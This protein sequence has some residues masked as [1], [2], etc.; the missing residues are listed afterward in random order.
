MTLPVHPNSISIDSL[1]IEFGVSGTKSLADFYSGGG[2]VPA[3]TPGFPGGGGST[4][5]PSNGAISLGN[6]H[7]SS[8][9]FSFAITSNQLNLNLYSAAVAAGWNQ[10]S[11]VQCQIQANVRVV[12]TVERTFLGVDAS[13]EWA[14]L[15][16]EGFPN[17]VTLTNYGYILGK[18]GSGGAGNGV[19]GGHGSHAIR[20]NGNL[21]IFNYGYIAGGGGGGGGGIYN[22]NRPGRSI[23]LGGG[24]GAGGGPGGG[25]GNNVPSF[26]GGD[27]GITPASPSWF[28]V[29]IAR[30]DDGRGFDMIDDGEGNLVD[31][32]NTGGKGGY[33]GGGGAGA[34]ADYGRSFLT[35]GA[36][37]GGG[38][39]IYQNVL[40]GGNGAQ[41]SR[42]GSRGGNGGSISAVGESTGS[43][44]SLAT[45]A[46]GGGG[47]GAEG[48]LG[49]SRIENGG[50][51]LA[52]GGLGGY[53]AW[54]QNPGSGTC[55]W[56]EVGI[57]YGAVI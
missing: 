3:N 38:T 17:G 11:P 41:T 50:F 22:Y 54:R 29:E 28:D 21:T 18:G 16:I 55:T 49:Y 4:T 24:G 31:V 6:F 32:Y 34:G 26:P 14:A 44:N 42:Y 37:G 56:A 30:G 40:G 57:R 25:T 46:G 19:R 27:G 1:R 48:G 8:N 5:I 52:Q 10:A 39:A 47:W 2:I 15:V 51:L 9:L 20:Y 35:G 23:V 12:S 36:G 53:A 7:G 33:N 45:G 43:L 13:T